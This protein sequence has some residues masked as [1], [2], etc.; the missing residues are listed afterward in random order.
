MRTL[1]IVLGLLSSAFAGEKELNVVDAQIDSVFMLDTTARDS[2]YREYNEHK[3]ELNIQ[4]VKY[5][6]LVLVKEYKSRFEQYDVNLTSKEYIMIH[7]EGT[8]FPNLLRLEDDMDIC[9]M[10]SMYVAENSKRMRWSTLMPI[11][12]F[13]RC[14]DNIAARYEYK[15]N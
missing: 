14:A 8:W 13:I 15:Y 6:E 7:S 9:I 2:I 4:Y 12:V 10:K 5:A 11:Y 1:L 3:H